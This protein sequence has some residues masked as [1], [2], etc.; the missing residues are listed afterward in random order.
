MEVRFWVEIYAGNRWISLDP[1]APDGHA[2]D[3][4]LRLRICDTRRDDPAEFWF[5]LLADLQ[6][7]TVRKGA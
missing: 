5:G 1:G 6:R 7:S 3:R 2:D 4:Y